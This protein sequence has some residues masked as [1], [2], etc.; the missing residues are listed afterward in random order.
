MNVNLINDIINDY[1]KIYDDL[2]RKRYS[3]LNELLDKT[4]Q[5][6]N[7]IKEKISSEQMNEEKT[8]DNILSEKTKNLISCIKELLENKL[9]NKY[10]ISFLN[11]LKKCFQYKLWSK[12]NSHDTI[13]IMKEISSNPKSSI[14]CLNKL[15]EIIHTI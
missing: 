4:K 12:S 15:V 11:I 10:I 5:D 6:L 9:N 3:S 2:F 14:E 8:K 1:S 13:E 7:F